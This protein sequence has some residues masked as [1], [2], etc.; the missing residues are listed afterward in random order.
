MMRTR[1]LSATALIFLTACGAGVDD[2]PVYL[3]LAGPVSL[4][5][6]RS[7]R[8]AAEMAVD[9][10]NMAGGI[11]GRPLQLVIR[12]DEGQRERAIDIAAE[13][14][15]D[16]RV[17]AVI[18]HINSPA[19]LAAAEIYNDEEN[20]VLQISPASS[21]PRISEAGAWT[22]RV[23][24]S[25]LQHGPALAAW[26][27]ERL[28]LGRAAVLYANDEYGRGVLDAFATPFQ[29]AG[30]TIVARDPFLPT[31][32]ESD[33]ALDPYLER[34]IRAGMDALVVV[35][36]AEPALEILA[37]AR[38]LGFTGP[39]LGADGITG[40]KDAGDIADGVYITSAFLPDRGA[41]A[42]RKFVSDY[43]EK[44]TELP[45]HRGAMTYD[46]VYLVA[47]ALREVGT[48]RRALRDYIAG[49][50]TSAPAYDGVSGA[51]VFD[52]NGDVSGK[53]V[54]VGVVRG[55]RIVTAS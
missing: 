15:D 27:Y 55:G 10:I 21:S 43:I 32:M 37:A 48:D 40:L 1:A 8:L 47:R 25:D 51:I 41:P 44:F 13:L 6:G 49:V 14:R 26:T 52:E 12:D 5:N 54:T 34:A 20:G 50:G 7:M 16:P 19:T 11:S 29:E 33:N 4:A 35:S 24:P 30:G 38:R 36:Q 31:I 46:A 2:G 3:G 53:E 28:G 39:V 9:E 42:A 18:G 22:F 17:V 45:D 23:C